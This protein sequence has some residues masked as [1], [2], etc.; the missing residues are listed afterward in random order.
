[1]TAEIAEDF[2]EFA[3]KRQPTTDRSTYARERAVLR[4]L[5]VTFAISGVKSF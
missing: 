4:V 5:R 3:E 2:E 1:L